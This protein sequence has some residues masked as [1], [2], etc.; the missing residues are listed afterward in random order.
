MNEVAEVIL[1][2]LAGIGVAALLGALDRFCNP[3]R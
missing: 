3:R 1:Y 2:L